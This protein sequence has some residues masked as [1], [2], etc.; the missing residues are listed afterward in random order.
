MSSK[1]GPDLPSAR[2]AGAPPR[3]PWSL[4]A[5]LTAWYAGSAFLLVLGATLFLYW[6]L[7]SNLDREDDESLADQARLQAAA[8]RDRP[9]DS[10]ARHE[11]DPTATGRQYAPLL[12]RV[13][14]N[15]GRVVTETPGMGDALPPAA[16]PPP[17]AEGGPGRAADVPAAAGRSFRALA[18]RGGPGVIQVALDRTRE[19]ELLAGYRRSLWLVLLLALVACAV[20]GYQLARRGL[21][22]LREIAATAGRIRSTT[23]AEERLPAAGLPAELAELAGTFNDM[24]DRL[25]ESFARL[26]RFSADIAHELR[27]PVHILRGEAEVALGRPRSP[28]EYREVLGSC[29]EECGRLTRLIDSLLFIARAEDPRTQVERE[30]V[31]VGR[32]LAAVREFYE[33][34]AAEVGVS[35]TAEAADGLLADLSRPLLQR[36]VGNL[37]ANAL[38]HTA[39]GGRVALTAARDGRD[40]RVEVADTGCGI[41]AAHLPHVFDRFYR[42]D[43][44]R[45]SSGGVG[46]GLA[47]VKSIAD[48]HGG[49]V[50]LASEVGRGTRVT[51]R[52]PAPAAGGQ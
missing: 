47:I 20:G 43:S 18:V 8:W 19:E 16:F 39:P 9:G 5:R 36:A 23:L 50:S 13:L 15:E 49:S 34:A 38:A 6:A 4:A 32:E 48:V 42:A 21:R 33:A 11:T 10:A 37:V 28:E 29:L 35:L 40:V 7:T 27:T 1:T 25:E 31:D 52:F 44:A 12:V 3:R 41:A 51:L 14:D 30:R 2:P 24:L 26:A 22:P 45:S 46:L 17:G